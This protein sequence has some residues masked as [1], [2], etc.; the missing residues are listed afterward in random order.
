MSFKHGGPDGGKLQMYISKDKMHKVCFSTH[1]S[2]SEVRDLVSYLKPEIVYP[3]VVQGQ[4]VKEILELI[5]ATSP[6]DLYSLELKFSIS[7]LGEL[8]NMTPNN[9]CTTISSNS[10]PFYDDYYRIPVQNQTFCGQPAHTYSAAK[11]CEVFDS[12]KNNGMPFQIKSD[13]LDTADSSSIAI[14]SKVA[15]E[16]KEEVR[17]NSGNAKKTN[18]T[19]NSSAAVKSKSCDTSPLKWKF[20]S[21]SSDDENCDPNS[22]YDS[23]KDKS[24][25]ETTYATSEEQDL[26]MPELD[27]EFKIP[28]LVSTKTAIQINESSRCQYVEETNKFLKKSF[29]QKNAHSN[30]TAFITYFVHNT[31]NTPDKDFNEDAKKLK[32]DTDSVAFKETR[33]HGVNS[34]DCSTAINYKSISKSSENSQETMRIVKSTGEISRNDSCSVNKNIFEM[35]TSTMDNANFS[36]RCKK[37][38][39]CRNQLNSTECKLQTSQHKQLLHMNK[40]PIEISDDDNSDS[41]TDLEIV[42]TQISKKN[43]NLNNFNDKIFVKESVSSDNICNFSNSSKSGLVKGQMTKAPLSNEKSVFSKEKLSTGNVAENLNHLN[44]HRLHSENVEYSSS[45]SS[46][47]KSDQNER[48]QTDLRTKRNSISHQN[49]FIRKISQD[50]GSNSYEEENKFVR[51]L[52]PDLSSKMFSHKLP[53]ISAS[54]YERNHIKLKI[55]RPSVYPLSKTSNERSQNNRKDIELIDLFSSDDSLESSPPKFLKPKHDI[56][57]LNSKVKS[58]NSKICSNQN[59]SHHDIVDNLSDVEVLDDSPS[60]LVP[61]C[62]KKKFLDILQSSGTKRKCTEIN[63]VP[64]QK[65]PKF[66]EEE[67]SPDIFDGNDD[68]ESTPEDLL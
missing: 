9:K 44:E 68:F 19:D 15:D 26:K 41:P 55:N 30:S 6:E 48:N 22:S 47:S 21:L 56:N 17:I 51:K 33:T 65:S 39:S 64:A 3:N 16:L 28:D 38:G 5:N 60:L 37:S 31:I 23:S 1:S 54:R 20:P 18:A 63:D 13:A 45:K 66:E 61:T 57:S 42:F 12:K 46:S 2:L 34:E 52:M 8:R 10:L 43:S 49:F 67:N 24:D 50:L 7:P 11:K 25:S 36:A 29:I 58:D 35:K 59:F 62:T 40:M 27:C 4:T 14:K 53:D 32:P